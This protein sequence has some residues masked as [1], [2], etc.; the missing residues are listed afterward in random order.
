MIQK[1]TYKVPVTI[2]LVLDVYIEADGAAQAEMAARN[3]C[4]MKLRGDIETTLEKVNWSFAG[5][6]QK[7]V[8]EAL[9]ADPDAINRTFLA[10]GSS[11]V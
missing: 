7:I 10:E 1:I 4:D 3:H 2:Q 5:T 6:P 8:G 11:P 9:P